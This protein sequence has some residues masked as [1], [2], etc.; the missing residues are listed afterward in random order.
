MAHGLEN[1]LRKKTVPEAE[2]MARIT[3]LIEMAKV[4]VK[5]LSIGLSPIFDMDEYS[6]VT[7]IVDLASNS[8]KLF[9]IPC[10]IKCSNNIVSLHDNAALIHLYRIAQEAITNA[11]RHSRTGQIELSFIKENNEITM[12]IKDEG[13]GFALQDQGNGMGL[14]IMRYRASMINAS[15]NVWSELNKGT[16]VTCVFPDVMEG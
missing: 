2:D 8:E 5:S 14:E 3:H 7:A 10:I 1:T 15:I 9:G 6:L 12:T 4:Q 16:I 11:A 13:K